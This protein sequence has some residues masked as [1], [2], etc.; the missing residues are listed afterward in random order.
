MRNKLKQQRIKRNI[1]SK[2][3]FRLLFIRNL[4]SFFL[5]VFITIWTSF[6]SFITFISIFVFF[7]FSFSFY[8]R[9]ICFSPLD[10]FSVSRFA[11][12]FSFERRRWFWFFNQV[13]KTCQNWILTRSQRTHH[14]R[15]NQWLEV[16]SLLFQVEDH[17][18]ESEQRSWKYKELTKT[19][20]GWK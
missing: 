14:L 9:G 16:F 1:L 2:V 11:V 15:N 19:C 5:L 3:N 6:T 13:T 18:F 12:S 7:P 10:V 4:L 20:E 17:L 8:K